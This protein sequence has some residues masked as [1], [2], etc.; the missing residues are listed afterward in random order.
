MT[1]Q[2]RLVIVCL[3]YLLL[4]GSVVRAHDVPLLTLSL[5]GA[6]TAKA[7]EA[8]TLTVRADG[9]KGGESIALTLWHGFNLFTTTATLDAAGSAQWA[10][11]A[12]DLT[13]AGTSL[14]QAAAGSIQVDF[15]LKVLPVEP[16]HIDALST[17]NTLRAY[18]TQCGAFI[19]LGQDHFGNPLD[20][21]TPSKLTVR[22]VSGESKVTPLSFADGLTYASVCSLGNPGKVFMTADV[23]SLNATIAIS[24]VA[25]TP[26]KISLD[27]DPTCVEQSQRD[28]LLITLVAHVTDAHDQP[29]PDGTPLRFQWTDGYGVALTADGR[30][31]L[32]LPYP[33]E[34][35]SV[36]ITATAGGATSAPRTIRSSPSCASISPQR[37]N[38]RDAVE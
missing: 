36:S 12:G 26:A 28:S 18:G 1:F 3:L 16:D 6:T 7:G 14:V 24:Q 2:R 22:S 15:K 38:R 37:G 35:A 21:L 13:L 29:A 34:A 27:A 31:V 20:S 4:G 5:W 8:W 17:M 23:G 32:S 30:A 11:P 10:F 33:S 9:A 19:L 25:G